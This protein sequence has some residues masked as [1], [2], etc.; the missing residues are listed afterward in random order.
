VSSQGGENILGAIAIEVVGE[1]LGTAAD[2]GRKAVLSPQAVAGVLPPVPG[3][4]QVQPAVA[5]HIANAKTVG[6]SGHLAIV[7][8]RDERPFLRGF[9][10]VGSKPAKAAARAANK[11]GFAV[12]GDVGEHRRFVVDH[13]SHEVHRPG[14][15]VMHTRIQ[16][17]PCLLAGESKHQDVIFPVGVEIVNIGEEVIRVP[18]DAE[19]LGR[20]ER[21]LLLEGR[22]L[23]PEWPGDDVRLAVAI[24]VADC[25]SLG[26]KFRMQLLALP[27]D[28][29]FRLQDKGQEEGG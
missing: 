29:G 12:A 4:Q 2:A 11:L 5:V 3:L 19:G 14:G 20:V 21:L 1:H 25:G 10:P 23:P 13:L 28:L 17:Q 27:G 24:D 9:V 18:L 16:V 7:G 6:E 8:H 26:V 22:S 15:V